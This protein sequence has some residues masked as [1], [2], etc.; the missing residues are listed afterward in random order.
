M[1][2]REPLA[3]LRPLAERRTRGCFSLEKRAGERSPTGAWTRRA[4]NFVEALGKASKIELVKSPVRAYVRDI[5]FWPDHM[6]VSP[7]LIAG[8]LS[9]PPKHRQT[10][11]AAAQLCERERNRTD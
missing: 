1:G 5:D 4:G 3:E 2:S 8:A 6:A 10:T 7:S 11:L 9:E